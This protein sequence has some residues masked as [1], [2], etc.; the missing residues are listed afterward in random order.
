MSIVDKQ[1]SKKN[2]FTKEELKNI[3]S[4]DGDTLCETHDVLG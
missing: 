1:G 4:F 2:T 3:F